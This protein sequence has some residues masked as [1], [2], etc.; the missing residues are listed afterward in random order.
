ME[1][2]GEMDPP[3]TASLGAIH[4]VFGKLVRLLSEPGLRLHKEEMKALGVLK[5]GLQVLIEDYLMEPSDLEGP[6]FK[7]NY[8]MK[9]V[10]EL[11]YDIDDFVDELFH[12]AANAKI[13]RALQFKASPLRKKLP[14]FK[15]SQL[16]EKLSRFNA[17]QLQKKLSWRQKIVDEVSSFSSCLKEL[18]MLY[19]RYDLGS[20]ERRSG[21]ESN[22]TMSLTLPLA[23]ETSQRCYL[24]MDKD[25]DKLVGLLN[26]GQQECKVIA[27]IG[28][29]GVGKTTLAEELYQKFGFQFQCCAFLRLSRKPDMKRVLVRQHDPPV[30]G[31]VE[32]DNLSHE[33]KSYLNDKRY[34]IVIDGV[35]SSYIWNTIN[36]TLPKNFYSR[37]LITTEINHVAQ[38]CCVDNRKYIFK[39]EPFNKVESDEFFRRVHESKN[40]EYLKEISS[41]IAQLCSGLPLMMAI[42]ASILTRLPPSTEQWNVVK[43]SLSSKLEGIL[44]LIY[45]IIPHPLKA[46]MLYLG[47]YEEDDIILKDELLSQWFAEGFIDTVD[48]N[49]EK[50]VALIYFDELISYGLIQPVETRFDN[51]VLSFRVHYMIIDSIRSKA[52]QHNFAIAIDNHQTDVRIADKIRRLSLRFGNANDVT[53]PIGLRWLPMQMRQLQYLAKLKIEARLSYVPS[54]IFYLPRLQQ[55]ILP[56]E[57]TLPHFTEPMKSLHTLGC[58]DLSGSSTESIVDLG[59]MVNLQ[60]LHMTCSSGQPANLKLLGSVLNKL[61]NMKSLILVFTGSLDDADSSIMEISSDDFSVSSPPVLLTRWIKELNNLSILKIAISEMLGHDVDVLSVLPALTSLSV[62]IQRAP[63]ERI[64]F[65]KG[66]FVALKYFKLKCTVPWLKVEVDAMPNLEKLKLRFNVGLSLQRV[67]LHG[68]NLIN[69]EHLSRLKEIYAKVESE[70]SVDAGSAL[71]TGV[72]NDPRNPTITIQLICGFYGE[73][74]RLMTKD[75]I[76]LEENPDSITEDEVRQN[77]EKKQ[78][79]DHRELSS[80][81]R[82]T[83][84]AISKAFK[85]TE[86][87][88][89]E[90]VS[91][92]WKTD[93]QIATVGACCL[94]GA[95][96]QKT[97]FI[98]N[99]GNSRAVL[100][101]VSCIGQ[102]VAEQLSS[103]N[104]ANDAWKAKGLV[105]V[106]RAIGDAYLKYPQYS[107]EPLNKPILSANPSIVSRVLRPSDR[108]II[109]GS[110]VLWEY[111]SN[112]E[113]VEIVKNHQASGSAKMLVKAALHAAAKKHNLHYSD[114]L[115]MDRDNP[116]HVHE[117]VIAV[118]LFINYDQLLKGKQGRPLSIRYPRSI[119]HGLVPSSRIS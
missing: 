64:S 83:T 14:L 34:F 100:G 47:I 117:D 6:P 112:Q 84:D 31:T 25:M 37:I 106:L 40:A 44:D 111:L 98:A 39:K 2:G 108:F 97:L 12:A 54:D 80:S 85:A 94:V 109:F 92:Q 68:N 71:M 48:G 21:W 24:G 114:L 74:T 86:E 28:L 88:F 9:E 61:K 102:I 15:T 30:T 27:I 103:E 50:R 11:C 99:L 1:R 95:V 19:K 110:A 89:I 101:K 7:A 43:K 118:V 91:R 65:G 70:G 49:D 17:S 32:V 66:G 79:D 38:R 116:R 76:I 10:R 36:Q 46:C 75:D 105:Q 82:V 3:I 23:E 45:N 56:S 77:D 53:T 55:L 69:I 93:P 59:K 22:G 18:I 115:K 57:T 62:Y 119:Q 67:G 8:W 60:N 73:M 104:I 107:R 35:W 13:Q 78:V 113:A 72:W 96:Q 51:E 5:D 90:L 58:F 26:D 20:L 29:C 87:G 63:E 41:E 33:I 4:I 81:Q 42:V 16:Q 52:V